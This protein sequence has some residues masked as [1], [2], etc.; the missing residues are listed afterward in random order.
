M[1][2]VFLQARNRLLPLFVFLVFVVVLS[3]PLVVGVVLPRV[4][5]TEDDGT[6]LLAAVENPE[7]SDETEEL[8]GVCVHL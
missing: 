4:P 6:V 7:P 1:R 3:V 2:R 5:E 8:A